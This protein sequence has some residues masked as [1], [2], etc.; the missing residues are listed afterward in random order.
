MFALGGVV[1]HYHGWETSA[2]L[3]ENYTDK[4]HSESVELPLQQLSQR[5]SYY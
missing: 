2:K 3:H 1:N 4:K 5:K